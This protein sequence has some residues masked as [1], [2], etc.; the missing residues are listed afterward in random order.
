[1]AGRRHTSTKYTAKP[2]SIINM[3]TLRA[4]C[5][6]KGLSHSKQFR[7][8]FFARARFAKSL[9]NF[10]S[11]FFVLLVLPSTWTP[12]V[13]DVLR[14]NIINKYVQARYQAHTHA[15]YV[16]G[17]RQYQVRRIIP[18][19][20]MY[21]FTVYWWSELRMGVRT[22]QPLWDLINLIIVQISWLL[23]RNLDYTMSV[24]WL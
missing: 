17:T 23:Y 18:G 5:T 3:H 4:R 13:T 8:V 15:L 19:T 22:L 20:C 2:F 16:P 1:M 14:L 24:S 9:F 12:P 10:A 21:L 6:G 7:R 11:I